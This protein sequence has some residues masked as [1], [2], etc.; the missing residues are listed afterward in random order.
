MTLHKNLVANP[1]L[2][3]LSNLDRDPVPV[4]FNI[5][6][7]CEYPLLTPSMY[8]SVK[9]ERILWYRTQTSTVLFQGAIQS[10]ASFAIQ[11]TII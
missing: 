5:F 4:V 9:S 8:K 1:Y 3:R 7:W 6:G 11:K 10:L 2:G